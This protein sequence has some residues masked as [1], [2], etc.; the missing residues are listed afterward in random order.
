MT[1]TL[2]KTGTGTLPL[3]VIVGIVGAVI[4]NFTETNNCSTIAVNGTCSINVTFAPTAAGTQSASV[5]IT[6]NASTSPD[7]VG[8]SGTAQ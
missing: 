8:L 5:Q 7:M 2:T 4:N 1:V 6:S 3:S